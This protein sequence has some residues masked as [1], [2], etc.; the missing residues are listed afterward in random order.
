MSDKNI[1][2][3]LGYSQQRKKG[4]AEI[5]MKFDYFLQHN[6]SLFPY[7]IENTIICSWRLVYTML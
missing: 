5:R 2:L 4:I 1:I 7:H 6:F 3:K